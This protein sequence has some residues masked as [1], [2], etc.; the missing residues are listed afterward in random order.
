MSKGPDSRSGFAWWQVAAWT[1]AVAFFWTLDTLTKLDVRGR[2]GQGLSDLR[3]FTEQGT[4]ALAALLMIAFVVAW[5]RRFPVE[6]ERPLRTA[7]THLLGSV[8]F[9]AGHYALMLGLRA[10]VYG[11]VGRAYT[12]GPFLPNLWFEYKKDVKIYFVI[13]ALIVA[14]Q[15]FARRR[16]AEAATSSPGNL[17]VQTPQGSRYLRLD[18]VTHL[19]AARNYVLVHAGGRR[20]TVRSSLAALEARLGPGFVRVHRSFLVAGNAIDGLDRSGGS[21]TLEVRGDARVPVSRSHRDSVAAYLD[22]QSVP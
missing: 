10:V 1:A 11:F 7:G 20:F 13:V 3:L 9:A 8:G 6:P 15:A 22:A 18:R 4:S 2:T 14:Y 19:E 21:W 17:E 5:V 12:P 16:T